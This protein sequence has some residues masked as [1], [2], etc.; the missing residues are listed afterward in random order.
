MKF[1]RMLSLKDPTNKQ[2]FTP[3]KTMEG[4]FGTKRQKCFGMSKHLKEHP[5]N[6]NK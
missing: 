4:I 6:P 5:I 2:F 3:D 1:E